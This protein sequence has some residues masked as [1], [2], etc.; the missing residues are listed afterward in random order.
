M[1]LSLFFVCLFMIAVHYY[2]ILLYSP[3]FSN[4]TTYYAGYRLF[5][6]PLNF[7]HHAEKKSFST[8][9]GSNHWERRK[10]IKSKMCEFVTKH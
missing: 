4:M 7:T 1:Y 5:T 6:S 8:K 10:K 3:L 2:F 9:F